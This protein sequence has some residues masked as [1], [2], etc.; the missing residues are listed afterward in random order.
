[1]SI[2]TFL[3]Y[4]NKMKDLIWIK[5]DSYSTQY[6]RNFSEKFY[7]LWSRKVDIWIS[8]Y[9]IWENRTP[10]P[11]RNQFA[12]IA[13][14]ELINL[15]IPLFFPL[16]FRKWEWIRWVQLLWW[17]RIIDWLFEVLHL[18]PLLIPRFEEVQWVKLLWWIRIIDWSFEVSHFLFYTS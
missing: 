1:M 13:R 10:D 6:L 16:G 5:I 17:I 4:P 15:R 3:F 8:R 9:F 11:V 14:R 18:K 2:T 12:T 7:H